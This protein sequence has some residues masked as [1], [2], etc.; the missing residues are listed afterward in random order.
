MRVLPMAALLGLAAVPG[1]A[2]GAGFAGVEGGNFS[3]KMSLDSVFG[4]TSSDDDADYLGVRAGA[5]EENY[6]AYGTISV[7]DSREEVTAVW[8]TGSYDYLFR[9]GNNLQPF[10]GGN[11]GYYSHQVEDPFNT[12]DDLLITAFTLGLEG[13]IQYTT[14]NWLLEAG[15]REA[16]ALSTD[17]NLNIGDFTVDSL[18]QFYGSINFI[19]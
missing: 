1:S 7:P 19:F 6:R 11:L 8:L 15:L 4:S 13:G 12:G 2:S 14:G 17:D 9:A 5:L 10:I 16:T 3:L 18:G